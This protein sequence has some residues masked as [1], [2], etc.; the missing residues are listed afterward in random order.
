MRVPTAVVPCREKSCRKPE[1]ENS[2]S[3]TCAQP[4]HSPESDVTGVMLTPSAACV[5]CERSAE[6]RT[7]AGYQPAKYLPLL[8]PAMVVSTA[9]HAT[10]VAAHPRWP[11]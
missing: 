8:A 7:N 4:V 11:T 6:V 2:A 9:A 3:C 1:A 5:R 10:P